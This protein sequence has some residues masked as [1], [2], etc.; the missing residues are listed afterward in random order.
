[1]ALLV[2]GVLAAVL[3]QD[4]VKAAAAHD[5]RARGRHPARSIGQ[6]GLRRPLDAR[7]RRKRAKIV[8]TLGGDDQ[9]H[10]RAVRTRHRGDRARDVRSRPARRR[11]RRGHGDLRRDAL[12]ARR[13]ACAQ[14][15]LS[16]S[17]LP[18]KE[19]V[20]H[21]RLPED[22]AGSGRKKSTCPRARRSRRCRSP[23]SRRRICPCRPSRLPRS[24]FSGEERVTLDGRPHQPR[25]GRPSRTSRSSSRSTGAKSTR[26]PV[27]RRTERVGV[28]DVPAR[29]P[30][31]KRT[32]AA[33]SRGHRRAAEEQRLPLRA[34]AEPARVRA[35]HP[36]RGRRP[37]SS[38]YLTTALGI[39][40]APPFKTDVV[41]SSRVTPTELEHRSVV[42]LND[43][44][45]AAD[46]DRRAAE[47]VRRAGRRAVHRRWAITRR[48]R[49]ESPL[50]PGKLGAPVDRTVGRAAR[51][52][53]ST[54]AT[55]SSSSSRIRSSGNFATV[56]FLRYRR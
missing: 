46:A 5:R 26:R 13:C 14:S 38:F 47:A 52:A 21:Q 31:P 3:K 8:G 41:P 4:P 54:T 1:M 7:A 20:P 45:G 44:D 6:H 29:S 10:A 34:V 53:S 56:R 42:I 22:A 50:L 40:N 15:L 33:R 39:G 30:S 36:G 49:G 28:G 27:T 24:S 18:R 19:A 2:L 48:G 35:G 37:A 51:S 11:D 55:T 16:Q 17:Q 25:R 43:V 23:S 12:R 32:C 9:R